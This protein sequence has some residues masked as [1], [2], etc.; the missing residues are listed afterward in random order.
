MLLSCVFA[1]LVVIDKILKPQRKIINT[2]KNRCLKIINV[3]LENKVI[4]Q[5]L[6]LIFAIIILLF[7]TSMLF[8][9]SL[10]I[11]YFCVICFTT[12]AQ[13]TAFC[14]ATYVFYITS[15]WPFKWLLSGNQNIHVCSIAV[16]FMFYITSKWTFKLL[17]SGNLNIHVCSIPFLSQFIIFPILSLYNW[18]SISTTLLYLDML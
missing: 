12:V 17:L 18:C 6:L 7:N 2:K 15:N 5:R 14:T 11:C 4:E 8:S 3:P 16:I 9:S 10:R 1:R 13:K